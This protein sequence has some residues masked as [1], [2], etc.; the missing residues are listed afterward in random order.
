MLYD[1]NL[2]PLEITISLTEDVLID[3]LMVLN[4]ENHAS[5]FKDFEVFIKKI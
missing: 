4:L 1:C 3:T 5:F 2:E